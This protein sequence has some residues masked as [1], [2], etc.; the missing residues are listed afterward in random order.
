MSLASGAGPRPTRPRTRRTITNANVRTTMTTSLPPPYRPWSRHDAG[1]APYRVTDAPRRSQLTGYSRV[2]EP[3]R[4]VTVAVN[5]RAQGGRNGRR[6]PVP[7]PGP[8]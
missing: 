2:L 6:C 4:A 5:F 8:E 1:L 7:P 3:H